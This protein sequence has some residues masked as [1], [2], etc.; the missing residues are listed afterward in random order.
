MKAPTNGMNIGAPTFRPLCRAAMIMAH[1][2]REQQGEE[3]GGI[4]PSENL[5]VEDQ[6]HRHRAAGR[7]DFAEFESREE[8]DDE[9]D[10]SGAFGLARPS[11]RRSA[12][13]TTIAP[14]P[15]T[16]ANFSTNAA[17]SANS[18]SFFSATPPISAASP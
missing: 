4:G 11:R 18:P 5:R 13:T 3:A 2:V 1:F 10:H 9:L 6:R 8:Q 16:L 15:I 12:A 14:S 17:P 7:G